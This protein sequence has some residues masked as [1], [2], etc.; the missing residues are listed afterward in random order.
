MPQT[1]PEK[2][3]LVTR[4]AYAVSGILFFAGL[5]LISN[6]HTSAL[7]IKGMGL[8]ILLGICWLL[9]RYLTQKYRRRNELLRYP[10]PS[11]WRTILTNDVTFYRQL[12]PEER[13]RFE[14]NIHIFLDEKRITGIKT[15]VDDRVKVLVAASA[16]IPIFGFKEW[17]YNN[18]GEVLIYPGNFSKDF[19]QTGT[20]R[21]V[22]GMVGDGPMNRIMILSKPALISGFTIEKDGKNVG[23]HEFVH[24]LDSS[25]GEFDGIPTLLKRKYIMPWLG[26]IHKEIKKIKKGKSSINPYGATNRV[27]F[28]AVASEYF[29]ERPK[30]M[31]RRYPDLYEMLTQIF[32]QDMQSRITTAL[33]DMMHFTG[34]RVGRNAPCPCG[35]GKK[36]KKC[37]LIQ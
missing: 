29:F 16:V 11:E 2:A 30:E 15:E 5:F 7:W 25:D 19:E 33:R 31:Q 28:F 8:V 14:H 32:Q 1:A 34:K 26:I 35:S 18:L 36:Y 20:G 13:T 17:E 23:I 10:F 9:F 24:L 3:K 6:A 21:T 27:E 22:L 12:E 4:L 37:C